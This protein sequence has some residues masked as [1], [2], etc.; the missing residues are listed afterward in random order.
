MIYHVTQQTNWLKAKADGA[1]KAPSLSIEGFIHAS[2]KQ[3]VAGVLHRYYQNETGLILLH[4]DETKLT[5]PLKYE[6][7][8]SVNQQFPHIYGPINLEAVVDIQPIP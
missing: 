5:S 7:S 6:L 8:P 3:Q 4:I 1:Y 2:S